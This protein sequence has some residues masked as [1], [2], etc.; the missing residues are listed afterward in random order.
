MN[1]DPTILPKA[2]PIPFAEFLRAELTRREDG[3]FRLWSKDQRPE[4]M[5]QIPVKF[6]NF[7]KEG[8]SCPVFYAGAMYFSKDQKGGFPVKVSCML[9]WTDTPMSLKRAELMSQN[10]FRIWGGWQVRSCI[11]TEG[12]EVFECVW[13]LKDRIPVKQ[14]FSYG[15]IDENAT[16]H[17]AALSS[18]FEGFLVS[19]ASSREQFSL[20]PAKDLY[21]L[22]HGKKAKRKISIE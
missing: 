12:P 20:L 8:I 14:K 6:E 10:L 3:A 16:G 1:E 15:A 5:G 18:Y 2:P 11:Y 4:N 9:R 13:T 19:A 7:S 17:I 22:L 21:A